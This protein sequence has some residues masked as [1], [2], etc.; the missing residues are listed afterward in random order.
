MALE[1]SKFSGLSRRYGGPP[2]NDISNS[3]WVSKA[4]EAK[5]ASDHTT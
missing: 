3:E 1:I 2:W 4:L 5:L